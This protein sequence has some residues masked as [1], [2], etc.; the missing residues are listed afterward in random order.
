[1]DPEEIGKLLHTQE[2]F[3][4]G[5]KVGIFSRSHMGYDL[6]KVGHIIFLQEMCPKILQGTVTSKTIDV[7]YIFGQI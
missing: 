6:E 3:A 2:F 4:G 7:L 1:M 5:V